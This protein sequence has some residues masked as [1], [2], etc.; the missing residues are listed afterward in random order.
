MPGPSD[1]VMAIASRI[2]GNAI[3][4]STARMNTASTQPP[5]KPAAAPMMVPMI[6][7]DTITTAATGSEVRAPHRVRVN[8]SR[9][10]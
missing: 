6:T 5:K 8:T 2:G 4:M 3:V 9:P 7:D 10:S 1:A